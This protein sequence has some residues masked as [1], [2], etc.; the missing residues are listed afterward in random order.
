MKKEDLAYAT[1]MPVARLLRILRRVRLYSVE[2]HPGI[3]HSIHRGVAKRHC[4]ID[5]DAPRVVVDRLD[6]RPSRRWPGRPSARG[7]A[8][9]QTFARLTW[10]EDQI[11]ALIHRGVH[12]SDTVKPT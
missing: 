8:S 12:P 6:A 1:P 4:R 9:G 2:G 7:G 3:W 11:L 10:L 5:P